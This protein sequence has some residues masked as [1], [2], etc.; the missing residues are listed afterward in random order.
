MAIARTT[1][2][3]IA[4]SEQG[5]WEYIRRVNSYTSLTP[6]EE[7]MFA[8]KV[9]YE[10]DINAA[11]SL[12]ISHLKLV[13]KVAYS[14]RGYGIALMDLISEG[15]IGLMHA[16]KKFEPEK[17]FR[18]STYAVWWVKA[19]MQEFIL[20]SWSLVKIGTTVGQ[21]KLFFSLNKLKNRITSLNPGAT[22]WKALDDKEVTTIATQLG[23]TTSD[24]I[25][26]NS[27][28]SLPDASLDMK[29]DQENDDSATV[30]DMLADTKDSHDITIADAQITDMRRA[31]LSK[32][33]ASLNDRD[34]DIFISRNLSD[35]PLT[36]DDLSKRYGISNERVRQLEARA[37]ERVKA[38]CAES[39][40]S[41]AA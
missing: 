35:E 13:V 17:G 39:A 20:K 3:S 11:H 25:D 14:M 5:L 21:K 31:A 33:I 27:R 30:L 32:G 28:L 19:T 15:N 26:M 6:Q 4:S 1:S 24:V 8:H 9:R 7:Y 34:K 10:Q 41:V 23:V 29:M 12:V 36:L 37:L 40:A 2:L 16:V 22:P 18:F 38:V